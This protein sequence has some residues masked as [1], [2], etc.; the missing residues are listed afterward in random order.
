MA[1]KVYDLAILGS[2]PGGYVAAVRAAQLGS[3]VALVEVADLGGVC[4]NRGCIPT[5]T[6]VECARVFVQAQRAGEFGVRIAGVAVDFPAM[7]ARKAR[8]VET[9]RRGVEGLMK[10][11]QVE[12]I[13]GRG[14]LLDRHRLAI[15]AGDGEEV[16]SA[17]RIIIAT[18]SAPVRPAMF[19]F[20]GKAVLTSDEALNLD[21]LPA[22]VLIVG[23]GYIGCEFAGF[24]SALGTQV[25]IVEVMERLIPHTDEEIAGELLRSFKKRRVTVHLGT[26]VESMVTGAGGVRAKLASGQEVAAEKVI[27]SVGRQPNVSD[28]GLETAGVRVENG[29]VAVDEHCQTSVPNIYAIG[30]VT[31]KVMLAHAASYQ[32]KVA[33]EHMYGRER[34]ADYHVMPAVFFTSPQV[35]TVGLSE[36]QAK[37]RG[38]RVRCVCTPFQVLGKAHALGETSGFIKIVAEEKT[39]EVLGVHIIGP[40]ATSL[41][42]EA[43]LALRLECTVEELANTIH[44]HPTLPEGIMEAAE[45]WLGHPIHG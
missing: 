23:G 43:A 40:E 14:R 39:G 30:D 8:V 6:L 16:I 33:V 17:Q 15:R 11:Y 2:G 26:R 45:A 37:G 7:M 10:R 32:A 18:G 12:V 27:V 44:A 9:L 25:T 29:A 42:A 41:I 13:R 28:L 22:S 36:T 5:K 21:Y 34:R 4:L 24:F 1:Q 19:P 20:D 38:F 35:G 31:G 3:K